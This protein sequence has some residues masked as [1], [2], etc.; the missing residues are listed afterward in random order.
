MNYVNNWLREITLEQGA[1]SCPLDLPD[2]EYRLTLADS[3]AGAT[4]WEIVDATVEGGAA[5]LTRAREGTADQDWPSGSVIYCALTAGTLA[6]MAG[7]GGGADDTVVE[8]ITSDVHLRFFGRPTTPPVRLGQRWLQVDYNGATCEWVAYM[9]GLGDLMWGRMVLPLS[10]WGVGIPDN[11]Q[12]TLAPADRALA[13]N[14]DSSREVPG[15]TT[16]RIPPLVPNESGDMLENGPIPVVIVN[17]TQYEWTLRFDPSQFW[18]AG[19]GVE[20]EAFGFEQLG[21]TVSQ[22]GP[23]DSEAIV[24]VPQKTTVWIDL[25]AWGWDDDGQGYFAWELLAR[26]INLYP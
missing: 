25:S 7:G 23:D 4:R 3:A 2:G 12:V 21:L 19:T 5:T 20:V 1:T 17:E 6:V 9:D 22:A 18:V 24:V 16:I 14:R 10:Q 15:N 26:P 13:L 11:F 8:S